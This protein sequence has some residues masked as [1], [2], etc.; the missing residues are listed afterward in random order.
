MHRFSQSDNKRFFWLCGGARRH[1]AGR[2]RSDLKTNS[3]ANTKPQWKFRGSR[4]PPPRSPWD[5]LS[6]PRVG[7]FSCSYAV[8]PE[9]ANKLNWKSSFTK[10]HF[11]NCKQISLEQGAILGLK[12]CVCIIAGVKEASR[13]SQVIMPR[14]HNVS[15]SIIL[16]VPH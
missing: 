14:P 13:E 12:H 2:T 9:E 7:L 16:R 3:S 1:K 10:P 8:R 4:H 6:L 15:E 5:L 11:E